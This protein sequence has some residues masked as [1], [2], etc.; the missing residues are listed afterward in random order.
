MSYSD[1]NSSDSESLI[2]KIED[3]QAQIRELQSE[4]S[5][6]EIM[7]ETITEHSTDL[8]N[9]IYEQNQQMQA[10]LQ[11]VQR[12]TAAAAAVENDT[13]EAVSLNPVADRTDELGQLARVFQRMFEQVKQRERELKQQVRQL[14]QIIEID[15]N[16]KKQRVNEILRDPS[17]HQLKQKLGRLKQK[18]GM[19]S[20]K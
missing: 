7:V 18:R 9:R 3:F 17:F 6:L 20:Q 15:E 14:E 16:Q 12:V 2:A 11:E 4:R 5:D 10:Y 8:E 13:F 19:H 1:A